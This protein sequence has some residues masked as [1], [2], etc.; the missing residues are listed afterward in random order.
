M[1]DQL[2]LCSA[3]LNPGC[4]ARITI[5]GSVWD[6]VQA[7]NEAGWTESQ[8]AFGHHDEGSVCPAHK[9]WTFVPSQAETIY[10]VAE[11]NPAAAAVAL[12]SLKPGM[13]RS[14]AR[15]TIEAA[16]AMEFTTNGINVLEDEL[17]SC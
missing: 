11:F 15:T 3:R 14:E 6:K 12:R 1:S 7:L 16:L 13:S 2:I 5:T 10:W 9:G 4:S 8:D 17:A